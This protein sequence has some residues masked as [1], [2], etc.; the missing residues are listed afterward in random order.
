MDLTSWRT[1][2]ET[3]LLHEHNRVLRLNVSRYS[4]N[5]NLKLITSSTVIEMIRDKILGRISG[6][7]YQDEQSRNVRGKMWKQ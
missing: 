3:R 4:W 1:R 2:Y 7:V 6:R 5:T